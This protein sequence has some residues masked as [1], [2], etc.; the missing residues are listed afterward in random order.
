M[1]SGLCG[2]IAKCSCLF[3]LVCFT[4][5]HL[6]G[7]ILPRGAPSPWRRYQGPSGPLLSFEG[8]LYDDYGFTGSRMSNWAE[9][10]MADMAK[11]VLEEAY[12][13][14]WQLLDD[15]RSA[16]ERTVQVGAH[17]GLPTAQPFGFE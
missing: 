14:T 17:G 1:F 9:E 16:L 8:N 15:H 3:S 4:R 6:G 10:E 2:P 5:W 13:A 7:K 12:G 11:A